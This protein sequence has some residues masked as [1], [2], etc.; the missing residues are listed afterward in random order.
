MPPAF[1]YFTDYRATEGKDTVDS[2]LD[3]SDREVK[4]HT[5]LDRFAFGDAL[6][7]EPCRA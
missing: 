2:C 3:I 6:Q 5:I 7:D 1:T 4:M